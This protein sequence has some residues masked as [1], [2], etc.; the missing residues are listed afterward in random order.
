MISGL[1]TFALGYGTYIAAGLTV[2]HAVSGYLL[3]YVDANTAV[4]QV[5]E[6]LGLAGLRRAVR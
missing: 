2:L 3:G 1:K 4:K 5:I 6:G